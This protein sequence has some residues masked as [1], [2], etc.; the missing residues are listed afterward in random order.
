MHGLQKQQD[1]EDIVDI[2]LICEVYFC[3]YA[4]VYIIYML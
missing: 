1:G 3:R 2:V 4:H